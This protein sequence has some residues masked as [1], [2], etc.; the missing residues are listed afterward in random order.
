MRALAFDP[1]SRLCPEGAAEGPGRPISGRAVSPMRGKAGVSAR[2]YMFWGTCD[3]PDHP[4]ARTRYLRRMYQLL[5]NICTKH[6]TRAQPSA[7]KWVRQASGLAW[8][9][10]R[11]P[12]DHHHPNSEAVQ[13]LAALQPGGGMQGCRGLVASP[14]L[15]NNSWQDKTARLASTCQPPPASL[16]LRASQVRKGARLCPL[17]HSALLRPGSR[18]RQSHSGAAADPRRID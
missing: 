9:S 4:A 6:P 5:R 11:L 2:V 10:S 15:P 3:V 18:R 8:L 7:V 12:D 1:W 17:E 16:H 13:T 14:A